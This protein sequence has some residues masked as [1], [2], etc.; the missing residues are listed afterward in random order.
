MPLCETLAMLVD[1]VTEAFPDAPEDD[2][3]WAAAIRS[4]VTYRDCRRLEAWESNV[5]HASP[6]NRTTPL[7]ELLGELEVL[8]MSNLFQ[9]YDADRTIRFYERLRS[10]FADRGVELP[11]SPDLQGW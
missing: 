2:Q 7:Q 9:T 3:R 4:I 6:A 11:I 10:Y 8:G 1:A 5:N